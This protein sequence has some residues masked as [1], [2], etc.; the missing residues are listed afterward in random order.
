MGLEGWTLGRRAIGLRGNG[1]LLATH[2]LIHL[3]LRLCKVAALLRARTLFNASALFAL[4]ANSVSSDKPKATAPRKRADAKTTVFYMLG[5]ARAAAAQL[6]VGGRKCA[7][8]TAEVGSCL[9]DA[10]PEAVPGVSS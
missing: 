2:S 1:P 9:T 8:G 6:I 10:T 3:L 7:S 5:P 4:V